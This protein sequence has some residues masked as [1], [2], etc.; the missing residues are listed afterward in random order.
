M[1]EVKSLEE[2]IKDVFYL[3]EEL[4][5]DINN[6]N[7]SIQTIDDK[8]QKTKD[9]VFLAEEKVDV[10]NDM[11]NTIKKLEIPYY[12]F[13]GGGLGSLAIIYNPY[14]GISSIV[15]GM[16]LGSIVGYLK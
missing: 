1:K 14:V 7:K 6:Q 15:G 3:F 16:F 12:M 8:I 4:Y 11:S 2:E 10:S 5:E 9:E 13:I